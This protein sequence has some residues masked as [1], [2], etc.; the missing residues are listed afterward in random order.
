MDQQTSQ[1]GRG[2]CGAKL[3]GDREGTCKRPA[4]AGTDHVGIGYCKNH[5][6][7]TPTHKSHAL[8]VQAER[9]VS[10][11]G[12][13]RDISA[14]EAMLELVQWKATEVQFWQGKVDE[15]QDDDMTWGRTKSESGYGG[16]DGGSF[17][18]ETEESVPHIYI[19]LLHEAQRDLANYCAGALR[20]GADAAMVGLAQSRAGLWLGAMRRMLADSRVSVD[21]D[22]EQVLFDALREL[23]TS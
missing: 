22:P 15:L 8:A 9:E 2:Y 6:G 10:K 5:G 21:G 20:A 4:G 3:R 12:A 14:A 23:Q 16:E 19:K 1:D 13:R 11:W 17:S 18:R 7:S